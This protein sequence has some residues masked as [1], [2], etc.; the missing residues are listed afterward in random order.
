MWHEGDRRKAEAWKD[1]AALPPPRSPEQVEEAVA[2]A[3]LHLYNQGLPCGA[4]A[5]R[6]YLHDEC[7]RPLPS[8]RRIGR[9]LTLYGLTYG[10]TG[11]CG[12]WTAED[13]PA[14]VPRSAWVPP[15]QR[16]HLSRAT[17][18]QAGGS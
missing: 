2:L 6:R 18:P 10:R 5:V 7:L 4:A 1:N 12:E 11:W 14:G 9:L 8:T 3:R 16:R 15:A 17:Q 13:L